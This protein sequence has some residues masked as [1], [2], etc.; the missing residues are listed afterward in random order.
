MTRLALLAVATLAL[1]ACG[2]N[3]TKEVDCEKGLKYQ[4]RR[5]PPRVVAPDDLDQLN[6]LAE[7]PIP[8]ADPNAPEMPEGVCND[9]P[10]LIRVGS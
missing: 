7:M 4:D 1:S 9:Q 3:D 8:R 5:E 6:E 10:P 2:G